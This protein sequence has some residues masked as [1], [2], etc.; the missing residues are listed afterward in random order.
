MSNPCCL[1]LK[2][3]IVFFAYLKS[4]RGVSHLFFSRT[5]KVL[6]LG[7]LQ[8]GQSQDEEQAASRGGARQ[9][10]GYWR[11]HSHAAGPATEEVVL[12]DQQASRLASTILEAPSPPWGSRQTSLLLLTHVPNMSTPSPLFPFHPQAPLALT[13]RAELY[14]L[15]LHLLVCGRGGVG[16]MEV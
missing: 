1:W 6:R 9:E 8:H 15:K 4:L 11:P 16:G 13:C 12:G 2:L 5:A 14:K 3:L 7:R 10:P